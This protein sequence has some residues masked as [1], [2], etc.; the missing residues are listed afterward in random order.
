VVFRNSFLDCRRVVADHTGQ[1]RSQLCRLE[2]IVRPTCIAPLTNFRVWVFTF[3]FLSIG[4]ATRWRG[5]APVRGN[6]LIAFATGVVVN[7]VLGFIL[8]ALMFQSYWANLRR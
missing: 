5:Y 1:P 3:S 8:S 2:T 4:L 6:A 7:L